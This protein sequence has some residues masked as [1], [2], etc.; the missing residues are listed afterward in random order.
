MKY[1][2]LGMDSKIIRRD[3]LQGLAVGASSF[4]ICGH[5]LSRF[6]YDQKESNFKNYC[7]KGQQDQAKDLGHFVRFKKNNT[8]KYHNASRVV[9]ESD[10]DLVVIGAGISGLS[11]AHHFMNEYNGKAKILILDNNSII[12]GHASRNTFIYQG[13]RYVGSGGT[14]AIENLDDSPKETLTA[15]KK[16][17]LD[18]I[19]LESYRDKNFLDKYSLS[20]SLLFDPRVFGN[21]NVTWLKEFHSKKYREFFKDAPISNEL[22]RELEELYSTKKNYLPSEVKDIKK[23]LKSITWQEYIL[24]YMGL[25]DKSVKMANLYALD[26]CGMGCDVVSAWDGYKIGPGFAG[27]GG[28]GFIEDDNHVLKYFYD[29]QLRFPDGN[30]TIAKLFLKKLLPKSVNGSTMSEIF[31]NP[32][33][34]HVLDL[35]TENIKF[36]LNSMATKVYHLPSRDDKKVCTEYIDATGKIHTLKSKHVIMSGGGMVAKHIVPELGPA[37]ITSLEYYKYTPVV[38]INVLLKNWKAIYKMGSAKMY[39]PDG[40]CTWMELAHPLK[41]GSYAPLYHPD[42]PIILSIYKYLHKANLSPEIQMK[43]SRFELEQKSFYAFEAEIRQELNYLLG[44]WGFDAA[45]DVAGIM[46]NRWAHGYNFFKS[47]KELSPTQTYKFGRKKIGNISFA[48]ADS[49]GEP[50]TQEAIAQG[51]RA[52]NEQL[53]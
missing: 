50:W 45:R 33:N 41:V 15:F 27:I 18:L 6:R 52:A 24:N 13:K 8:K 26:L 31:N 36:R 44:P 16:I 43:K 35:T 30:H 47:S 40:Y 46:V 1:S 5:S 3:F 23:F 42:N 34:N 37:Q 28:T 21:Q 2:L 22:K 38:Y 49:G 7:L 32:I 9:C 51:I 25:G 19:E 11:A 17:G 39:L 48:G 4:A 20:S 53:S 10:L 29:P 12:G 14:Y